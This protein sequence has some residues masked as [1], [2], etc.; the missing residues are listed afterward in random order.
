MKTYNNRNNGNQY[1]E[2]NSTRNEGFLKENNFLI[3]PLI[4]SL[5]CNG[6]DNS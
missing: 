3:A 4:R 1:N 2:N 5:K 6:N